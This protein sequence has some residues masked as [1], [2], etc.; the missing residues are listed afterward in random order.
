MKIKFKNEVLP[1]MKTDKYIWF[2]TRKLNN[3]LLL[4]LGLYSSDFS[5]LEKLANKEGRNFQKTFEKLKSL[6]DQDDPEAYLKT[7]L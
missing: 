1:K 3:A 2:S 5:E 4:L 6:E 7:L